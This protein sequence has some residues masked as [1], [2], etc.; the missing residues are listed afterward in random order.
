[1]QFLYI[2]R[3]TGVT[4]KSKVTLSLM[5]L[6]K[7]TKRLEEE[8]RK[9]LHLRLA[10]VEAVVEGNFLEWQNDLPK[11]VCILPKLGKKVS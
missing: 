10:V 2:G 8:I 1:M 3:V 9:S 4:V 11:I 6:I 5:C 7:K